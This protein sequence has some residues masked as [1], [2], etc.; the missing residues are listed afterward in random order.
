MDRD[1]VTTDRLQRITNRQQHQPHGR[2]R[3]PG[4]QTKRDRDQRNRQEVEQ[5]EPKPE[6]GH[7]QPQRQHRREHRRGDRDDRSRAVN[8]LRCD[9]CRQ[10]PRATIELPGRGSRPVLSLARHRLRSF[11]PPRT[12]DRREPA[13]ELIGTRPPCRWARRGRYRGKFRSKNANPELGTRGA[14][15][16]RGIWLGL[17]VLAPG[18]HLTADYSSGLGSVRSPISR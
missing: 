16:R 13:S 8:A 9:C 6:Q 10:L 17:S 15:R 4:P 5:R 1:P 12:P 14:R 3:Y 2:G 7:R 18:G 11:S